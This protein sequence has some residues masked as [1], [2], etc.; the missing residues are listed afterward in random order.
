MVWDWGKPKPWMRF[1]LCAV[2]AG[3][4]WMCVVLAGALWLCSE[5]AVAVRWCAVCELWGCFLVAG[6]ESAGGNGG[7]SVSSGSDWQVVSKDE[8]AAADAPAPAP[9]TSAPDA[10]APPAPAPAIAP[11]PASTVAHDAP[12]AQSAASLGRKDEDDAD[13]LDR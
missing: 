12:A 11:A 1:V 6:A 3:A 13:V 2:L 7:S 5:L 9:E 10:S 4:L 8:E